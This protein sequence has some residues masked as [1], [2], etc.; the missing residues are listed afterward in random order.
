M[1]HS[2]DI[3][4]NHVNHTNHSSDIHL[5]HANH[6]NHSSDILYHVNHSQFSRK[7]T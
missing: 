7:S 1:N 6:T 3:H 4:F 2:S 5:N